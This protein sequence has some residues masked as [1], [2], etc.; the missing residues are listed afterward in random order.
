MP[1]WWS[2]QIQSPYVFLTLGVIFSSLSVLWI[3]TGKASTRYR[4]VYRIQEPQ[5]FW[6]VIAIYLVGSALFFGIFFYKVYGPSH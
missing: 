6:R 4:W 2:R 1:D 5:K 3:C